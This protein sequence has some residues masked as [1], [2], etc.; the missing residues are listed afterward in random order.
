MK[1]KKRL[2]IF[3]VFFLVDVFLIGGFLFFQYQANL[4]LL[5]NEINV[6]STLDITKDRYN[7]PL[8][9]N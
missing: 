5:R 7:L 1:K 8:K 9:T 3:L 6:L 4:N 2:V